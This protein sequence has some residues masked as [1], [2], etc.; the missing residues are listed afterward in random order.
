MPCCGTL[1]MFVI[2]QS[3]KKRF[4]MRLYID[5]IAFYVTFRSKTGKLASFPAAVAALL[6]DSADSSGLLDLI[7]VT[8]ACASFLCLFIHVGLH[9]FSYK[10]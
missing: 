6:L 8:W 1:L 9:V 10:T 7:Q 2:D 5:I 4:Y 3:G